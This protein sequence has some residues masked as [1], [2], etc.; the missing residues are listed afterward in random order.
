MKCI[1]KPVTLRPVSFELLHLRTIESLR[2]KFVP[3][4]GGIGKIGPVQIQN[5]DLAIEQLLPFRIPVVFKISA[6][7]NRP[8]TEAGRGS[9]DTKVLLHSDNFIELPRTGKLG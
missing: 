3:D 2:S 7:R 9:R 1:P 5:H 8:V 6:Q 4:S